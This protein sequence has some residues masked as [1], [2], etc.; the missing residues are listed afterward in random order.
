VERDDQSDRHDLSSRTR[1]CINQYHD[2]PAAASSAPRNDQEAHGRRVPGGAE[3]D[4]T[5]AA[6][7]LPPGF[8][9]PHWDDVLM[10]ALA[11]GSIMTFRPPFSVLSDELNI[12]DASRRFHKL[13]IVHL[14]SSRRHPFLNRYT[15]SRHRKLPALAGSF[16]S[17]SDGGPV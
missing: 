17:V 13:G 7:A 12:C 15:K 8:R 10:V 5:L 2:P 9:A 4:I 3:T 14:S 6:I 11:V 16:Q 1:S